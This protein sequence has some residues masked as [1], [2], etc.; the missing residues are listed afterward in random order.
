[1]KFC[2]RW[3]WTLSVFLI[4]CQSGPS[5]D[6]IDENYASL[7]SWD[8]QLAQQGS[9]SSAMQ[10]EMR[11]WENSLVDSAGTRF[12]LDSAR[13]VK[14]LK[15]I[16][17]FQKE[18]TQFEVERIA[19]LARVKPLLLQARLGDAD[20]APAPDQLTLVKMQVADREQDLQSLKLQ[21]AEVKALEAK[22]P[23]EENPPVPQPVYIPRPPQPKATPPPTFV[24]PSV[25][26]EDD[27]LPDLEDDLPDDGE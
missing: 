3:G 26:E 22:A 21:F 16:G 25:S 12:G 6:P 20:L 18:R 27:E 17:A 23:P 7:Q 4:S 24:A 13:K 14:F 19:L 9:E 15:A 8:A 10:I 2:L 1:M 5:T 11:A